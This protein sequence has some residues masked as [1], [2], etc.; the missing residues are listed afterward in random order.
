M[1]I[2]FQAAP[3]ATDFSRLKRSGFTR[4]IMSHVSTV[5][6][7]SSLPTSRFTVFR[8]PTFLFSTTLYTIFT[9]HSAPPELRTHQ[10]PPFEG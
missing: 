4:D 8:I 1:S 9:L 7:M 10:T 6:L 2:Y 5:L 3:A